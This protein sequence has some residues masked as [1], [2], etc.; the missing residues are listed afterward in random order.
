VPTDGTERDEIIHRLRSLV[1]VL[2]HNVPPLRPYV[3]GAE[4]LAIVDDLQRAA[5]EVT[6][7]LVRLAQLV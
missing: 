3:R 2:E 7:L 6:R 1:M 4:G 5:A